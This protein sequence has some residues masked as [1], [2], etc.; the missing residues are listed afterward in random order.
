MSDPVTPEAIEPVSLKKTALISL[1]ISSGTQASHVVV[2]TKENIE[3]LRKELERLQQQGKI[4]GYI[5]YN[6]D[7]ELPVEEYIKWVRSQN[8][9]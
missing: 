7:K 8:I 6:V 1:R 5:I 2:D 3:S 4:Y 9:A